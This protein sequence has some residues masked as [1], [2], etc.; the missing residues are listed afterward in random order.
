MTNWSFMTTDQ[1][2]VTAPRNIGV[3]LVCVHRIMAAGHGS[4]QELSQ[5]AGGGLETESQVEERSG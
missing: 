2:S 5:A 4:A 3:I 1:P